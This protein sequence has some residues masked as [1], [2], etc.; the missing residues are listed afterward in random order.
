MIGIMPGH[1]KSR[2]LVMGVVSPMEGTAAWGPPGYVG[3][4]Q[5]GGN[6]LALGSLGTWE[7]FVGITPW[8]G[9]PGRPGSVRLGHLPKG[10][11]QPHG[12]GV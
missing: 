7:C 1:T 5:K 4:P 2:L 3:K 11:S 10:S 8:K 12:R 6:A 9:L